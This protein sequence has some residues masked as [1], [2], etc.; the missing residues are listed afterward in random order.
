MQSNTEIFSGRAGE[1]RVFITPYV[2]DSGSISSYRISI[3]NLENGAVVKESSGTLPGPFIWDGRDALG[4]LCPDGVYQ[5]VLKLNLENGK[6]LTAESRPIKLDSTPPR[7]K[8]S[9]ETDIFSPNGD[10]S[11][12]KVEF[13][14]MELL[15]MRQARQYETFP[16][17]GILQTALSGMAVMMVIVSSLMELIA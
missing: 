8:V 16:G 7:V 5:A 3:R 13:N 4:V 11:R 10:G 9:E 2:Q 14:G 1:G 17:R 12:Q 6:V 15:L